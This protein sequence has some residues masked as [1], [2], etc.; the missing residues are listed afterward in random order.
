RL[1]A[2]FHLSPA[3]R[4]PRFRS[5]RLLRRERGHGGEGDDR[6]PARGAS[7]PGKVSPSRPR[8]QGPRAITQ[9]RLPEAA[10]SSWIVVVSPA[11]ISTRRVNGSYCGWVRMTAWDPGE[12]AMRS[13]GVAPS[14]RPSTVTL[15][16]GFGRTRSQPWA[17]GAGVAGTGAGAIVVSRGDGGATDGMAA[18]TGDGDGN[19]VATGEGTLTGAGGGV[20]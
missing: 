5:R 17:G 4:G 15:A 6:H 9:R 8:P 18:I 16:Q 19:G 20:L 2:R 1:I 10:R 7:H 11:R 13:R 14:A 3:H 12:S